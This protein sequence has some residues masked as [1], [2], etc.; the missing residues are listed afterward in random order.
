MWV[1]AVG[2]GEGADPRQHPSGSELLEA[3]VGTSHEVTGAGWLCL[4]HLQALSTSSRAFLCLP[5]G[6]R[7][8]AAPHGTPRGG[9]EGSE[10]IGNLT[11]GEMLKPPQGRDGGSSAVMGSRSGG[12]SVAG[13]IPGVGFGKDVGLM[14]LLLPLLWVPARLRHGGSRACGERNRSSSHLSL[15]HVFLSL[16]VN[17][18]D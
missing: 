3:M 15:G 10:V 17:R 18:F 14:H 8:P 9:P 2:G 16:I 6:G 12:R 7:V 13:K 4:A 1:L 11:Y 5:G